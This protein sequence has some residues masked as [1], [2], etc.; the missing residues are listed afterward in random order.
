MLTYATVEEATE[1]LLEAGQADPPAALLTMMLEYASLLVTHETRRAAFRRDAAG[2]PVSET[3]AGILRDAT[4]AQIACWVMNGITPGVVASGSRVVAS[5]S[6]DGASITY[7]DSER[8]TT[9]QRELAEGL[10]P[11][12]RMILSTAQLSGGHPS[13]TG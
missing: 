10:C 9:A 12:A 13:V 2:L 11:H 4:L 8:I 1:R 3:I 7:A 5:K 6:L